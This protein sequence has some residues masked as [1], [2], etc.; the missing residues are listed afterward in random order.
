MATSDERRE[1]AENLRD[2]AMRH[3]IRYEKQFFDDLAEVVI[4]DDDHHWFG[5][6]LGKLARL[7]DPT[8]EMIRDDCRQAFNC[9]N[10][11]KWFRDLQTCDGRGR[12]SDFLYC[13]NCGARV[14]G[15]NGD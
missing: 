15:P 7:I 8:C 13:P 6:V 5:V 9:T 3:K 11:G 14:V 10:C 12:W 4:G 1:V 2:V